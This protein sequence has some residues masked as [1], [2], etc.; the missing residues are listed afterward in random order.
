VG[1]GSSGEKGVAMNPQA[2][3]NK[4]LIRRFC[5]ENGINRFAVF[6]SALGSDFQPD[7]DIDI[8]VSFLPD[9]IPGLFGMASLERQLTEMIGR[10]VDLRTA[11]DLSRY[12][13]DAV[14]A[15]AE[16]QYAAT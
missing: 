14:L 12:F 11:E 10:K 13:R 4:D 1:A 6:G 3:I 5:K 9:R 7:S 8:L 16:V 2:C 15:E